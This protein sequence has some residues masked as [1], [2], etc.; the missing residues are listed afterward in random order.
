M[1]LLPLLQSVKEGAKVLATTSPS[2]RLKPQQ[3]L[4]PNPGIKDVSSP[5]SVILKRMCG[6]QYYTHQH[7]P[8]CPTKN[9]FWA[10]QS[11]ANAHRIASEN[12]RTSIDRS[13]IEA[14]ASEALPRALHSTESQTMMLHCRWKVST[15]GKEFHTSFSSS[16]CTFGCRLDSYS[17]GWPSSGPGDSVHL[18]VG[19]GGCDRLQDNSLFFW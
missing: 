17:S 11:D 4:I 8:F 19:E 12:R 3:Y 6:R 1:S 9:V 13:V 15:L 18:R 7:L 10:F 16:L 5:P 14:A 2:D